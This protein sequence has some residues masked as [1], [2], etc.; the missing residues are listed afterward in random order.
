MSICPTL[1][2]RLAIRE[3]QRCC[4]AGSSGFIPPA[5]REASRK[6]TDESLHQPVDL[7][8]DAGPRLAVFASVAE[9]VVQ[10]EHRHYFHVPSPIPGCD[11]SD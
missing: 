6:T 9:D 5:R 7:I 11:D 4:K 2:G 3:H 1:S 10:Y 8:G